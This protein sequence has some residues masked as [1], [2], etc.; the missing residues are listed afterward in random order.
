M[1]LKSVVRSLLSD[2]G[3]GVG[4]KTDLVAFLQRYSVAERPLAHYACRGSTTEVIRKLLLGLGMKERADFI[5]ESSVLDPE[6][7]QIRFPSTGKISELTA[8]LVA[9][10]R[11]KESF[12]EAL[13]VA[14]AGKRLP[15][16]LLDM[17]PDSES[18]I[19]VPAAGQQN[20][21]HLAMRIL[22]RTKALVP[23]IAKICQQTP[24][25][26]S[27]FRNL[28]I[29]L[30]TA[31]EFLAENYDLET[32]E[33]LTNNAP[34][35]LP[36]SV[37][38]IYAR[39][40]GGLAGPQGTPPG[41]A[42]VFKTDT[43]VAMDLFRLVRIDEA[44]VWKACLNAPLS[45]L[46]NT[47]HH[48]SAEG[49]EETN[50]AP[51]LLKTYLFR[52]M[53]KVLAANLSNKAGV[54]VLGNALLIH[55][56]GGDD[57]VTPA[58]CV[59][60][61]TDLWD[62]LVRIYA[63]A[64]GVSAG[65]SCQCHIGV[66]RQVDC[67]ADK[68][69]ICPDA[70][71]YTQQLEDA[72]KTRVGGGGGSL[73]AEYAVFLGDDVSSSY[74]DV[75]SFLGERSRF[76]V[77]FKDDS[78]KPD[79]SRYLA[80][81]ELGWE[82]FAMT[83]LDTTWTDPATLAAAR[84]RHYSTEERAEVLKPLKDMA[85]EA[86]PEALARLSSFTDNAARLSPRMLDDGTPEYTP[87]SALWEGIC[88]S[89]RQAWS[90]H[91][92]DL[93][94]VPVEGYRPQRLLLTNVYSGVWTD[95]SPQMGSSE[96]DGTEFPLP[97]TGH[98]HNMI[99]VLSALED[100][101]EDKAALTAALDRMCAGS[102]EQVR[103]SKRT[104]GSKRH[105]ALIVETNIDAAKFLPNIDG[106]LLGKRLGTVFLQ[107]MLRG[108]C[109]PACA[110]DDSAMCDSAQMRVADF[111]SAME[112]CVHRL[113]AAQLSSAS[114]S[115]DFRL[116]NGVY[117]TTGPIAANLIVCSRM[118]ARGR[119]IIIFSCS[120]DP[121][122]YGRMVYRWRCGAPVATATIMESLAE[123]EGAG[124][125][126]TVFVIA[127]NERGSLKKAD[128]ILR[129]QMCSRSTD[130]HGDDGR[131]S[132]SGS[133]GHAGPLFRMPL[134]EV[135]DVPWTAPVREWFLRHSSAINCAHVFNEE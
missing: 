107:T 116:P 9:A 96:D 47:R 109:N 121:S 43:K 6:F 74:S 10:I 32:G 73:I 130:Y 36:V 63:H 106:A 126:K 70:W 55:D 80:K 3:T 114:R 49:G 33:P 90:G 59:A 38:E 39:L 135:G 27:R 25:D 48:P 101:E 66:D 24:R 72:W 123:R 60:N 88:V 83:H 92:S 35:I 95:R 110:F 40:A 28:R 12:F 75:Y 128:D 23:V 50:E 115:G 30:D 46:W 131:G 52:G 13:H 1:K 44:L 71:G 34:Y 7:N 69:G 81:E 108:G 54:A 58:L 120:G 18:G 45:Y 125:D 127:P 11:G 51:N 22:K 14:V 134:R 5:V 102:L 4:P 104:E 20:P 112:G 82:W 76:Q 79:F 29:A 117:N 15:G 68:D 99:S 84:G 57:N 94:L 21:R 53:D 67:W 124:D 86:D 17:L 42:L 111:H 129:R 93:E 89:L 2:A 78:V 62:Y 132:N 56:E 37:L 77:K 61:R 64:Y 16:A 122:T 105:Y 103:F 113:M 91:S 119:L 8:N 118:D 26:S 85:A 133:E 19:V 65:L 97:W 41:N 100:T 98:T 31:E 87:L